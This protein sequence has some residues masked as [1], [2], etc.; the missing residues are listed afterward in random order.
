MDEVDVLLHPLKSELNF[1][2]GDKLPLDFS[3]ERWTCAIHILDA[4]FYAEKGSMSVAFQQSGRAHRV[5]EELKSVIEDGYE[6]RA[7]Q[8]SPHLVLLNVEW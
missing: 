5:L 3:P 6:H 8:R 4:V 7:L 1:P 2:V